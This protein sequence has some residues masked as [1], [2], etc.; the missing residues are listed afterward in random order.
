MLELLHMISRVELQSDIIY[1][2]K[3]A[4]IDVR[5]PRNKI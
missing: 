2:N 4:N 3:L 5:F 1:N